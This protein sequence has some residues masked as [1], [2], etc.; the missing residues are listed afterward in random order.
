M[1]YL[2]IQ[3]LFCGIEGQYVDI[4]VLY[5]DVKVSYSDITIFD[6]IITCLSL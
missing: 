1:D 2:E 3:N 6:F 5:H 4:I